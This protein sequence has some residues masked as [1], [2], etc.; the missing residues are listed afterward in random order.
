MTDEFADRSVQLFAGL[1]R[2]AARML[3]NQACNDLPDSLVALLSEEEWA[4]LA[5]EM[6]PDDPD[7]PS[8][9]A[10]N[11]ALLLAHFAT[12]LAEGAESCPEP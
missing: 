9:F 7:A 6:F 4:E 5:R 8:A 10:Q 3:H 1:L 12:R 11:Y 2:Y